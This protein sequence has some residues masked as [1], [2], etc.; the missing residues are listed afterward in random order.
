MK[1]K[2]TDD[3]NNDCNDN[4]DSNDGNFDDND[5]KHDQKTCKKITNLRDYYLVKKGPTNSGM[6]KRPPPFWAMPEDK[7]N[8][9]ALMSSLNHS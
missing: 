9:L 2:I 7:K 1:K 4:H 5:D 8:L 3:D 6:G